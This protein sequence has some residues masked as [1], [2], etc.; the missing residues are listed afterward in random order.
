MSPADRQAFLFDVRM[1]LRQVPPAIL[2]ELGKRR[3]PG[4]DFAEKAVG[5]KVLEH[6]LLCRWQIDA[7]PGAW[8]VA[9]AAV[10]RSSCVERRRLSFWYD[11]PIRNARQE[12][13]PCPSS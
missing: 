7:G 6:L 4:D 2:R 3:L 11:R 12:A 9:G 10:G 8:P 1:A 13:M 5:E